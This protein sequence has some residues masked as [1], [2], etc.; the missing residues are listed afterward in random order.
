M[1]IYERAGTLFKVFVGNLQEPGWASRHVARRGAQDAM[2][3]VAKSEPRALLR[4]GDALRQLVRNL[5]E[6]DWASRHV[7]EPERPLPTT[8]EPDRSGSSLALALQQMGLVRS[9][10]ESRPIDA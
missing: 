3:A 6:S 4:A 10:Q 2:P 1:A 7:G 5:H 8:D 9:A